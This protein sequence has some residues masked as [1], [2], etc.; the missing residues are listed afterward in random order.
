[1]LRFASLASGSKGN[2]LVA[3]SGDTRVLLDC[4]LGPRKT[5]RRLRELGIEPG[6]IDALLVTHDIAEAVALA[7]VVLVASPGPM[8]ITEAIRVN[9]CGA[10]PADHVL[11]AL[12]AAGVAAQPTV[13]SADLWNDAHLH[14]RGVFVAGKG[15]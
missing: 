9:E 12:R 4:G 5:A 6:S 1:M 2:C 3:E 13:N 15:A 8:R 14:E 10:H 7:H 11:D